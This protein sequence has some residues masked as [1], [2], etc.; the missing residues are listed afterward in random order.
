MKFESQLPHE[1]PKQRLRKPITLLAWISNWKRGVMTVGHHHA[2]SDGFLFRLRL[3][4]NTFLLLVK[5]KGVSTMYLY[6]YA[7]LCIF[8]FWLRFSKACTFLEM[9]HQQTT[10]TTL[11]IL[12]FVYSTVSLHPSWIYVDCKNQLLKTVF[13]NPFPQLL[14]LLSKD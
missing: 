7:Y 3:L 10:T 13:R 2:V 14:C 9:Q 6:L 4:V 8:Y 11:H 1:F 12:Y 5:R